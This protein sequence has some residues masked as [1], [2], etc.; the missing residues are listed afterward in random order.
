MK[1]PFV[2][3]A[4]R[5]GTQQGTNRVKRIWQGILPVSQR[6]LPGLQRALYSFPYSTVEFVALPI[7]PGV[8]TCS[9]TR[10][11]SVGVQPRFQLM[12]LKIWPSIRMNVR[13][14]SKNR[15]QF[16]QTLND[17]FSRYIRTRESKRE[18]GILIDDCEKVFVTGSAWKT[19]FE[20]PSS[21]VRKP[22]S[23]W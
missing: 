11:N 4:V 17:G 15:K 5:W 13:S 22:A 2:G 14:H 10:G 18:S 19:T 16:R 3:S 23:L 6:E 21:V 7:A 1:H 8:E 20:V 9:S 12:G